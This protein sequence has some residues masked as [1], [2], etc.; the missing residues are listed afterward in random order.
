MMNFVPTRLRDAMVKSNEAL[1]R[2]SR[3][4]WMA[5]FVNTVRLVT[6]ASW[7][8]Q[9]WLRETTQADGLVMGIG[10]INGDRFPPARSRAVAV[11]YDYMVVAGTQGGRGHYKQDRMYEPGRSL[12]HAFSVVC[13]RGRRT[14]RYQRRGTCAS[15]RFGDRDGFCGSQVK[16]LRA[17]ADQMSMSP[18]AAV[19]VYQLTHIRLRNSVI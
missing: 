10:Y 14:T 12:S 5:R 16:S 7:Q 15:T 18:V 8:D 2:T 1:K 11:H 13:G 9:Q 3:T 4:S 17:P 6:A 19:A